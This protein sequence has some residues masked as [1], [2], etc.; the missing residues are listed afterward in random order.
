MSNV[1]VPVTIVPGMTHVD[2]I[3]APTALHAVT[4]AVSPQR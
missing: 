2:M 3:A 4:N 1:K